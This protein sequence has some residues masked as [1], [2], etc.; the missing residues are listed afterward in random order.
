M[1]RCE[2]VMVFHEMSHVFH[3]LLSQTQ[4]LWVSGIEVGIED[5]GSSVV[6]EKSPEHGILAHRRHVVLSLEACAGLANAL[7]AALGER[8]LTIPFVFSL[9]LISANANA[10]RR[11]VDAF[12]ATLAPNPG[13][14]A[15]ATRADEVRFANAHTL[16]HAV[17]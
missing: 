9:Q 3:S 15:N 6:V 16:E 11:L 7:S 1:R 17:R 5:V 2:V 12:L 13:P 14:S 4:H 8:E 10:A